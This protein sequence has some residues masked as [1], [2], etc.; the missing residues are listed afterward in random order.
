M[1]HI[2]PGLGLLAGVLVALVFGNPYPKQSRVLAR[3]LLAAT[4][5][6]LGAGMDL[7]AV[8][9][10]GATG[11]VATVVGISVC[12]ALGLLLAR[13]LRVDRVTGLLI[14]VGT[15]ICGGSAIAAVTPG[16]KAND[17]Q[18]T[19]S[20]AT[21]FLLNAVALFVFP[22]VGRAFGLTED[23][24]GAWAALAI[25]DTSSVVGAAMA[26][27]PH[28]TEVA[29]TMKLA[30]ALWIVPL[31]LGVGFF[32]ARTEPASEEKAP[33]PWFIAGFLLAAALATFVP[34]LR[35]PGRILAGAA[36]HVMTLTL[37]L[38]GAG[39]TRA[40]LRAV[41]VRPFAQGTVLWLLVS[42]LTLAAVLH[43]SAIG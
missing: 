39:L 30:R 3:H 28:A 5:V 34:A 1:P 37:F 23:Q 6:G 17:E 22:P 40:T 24:F 7:R 19:A 4:V 27:G 14:A 43:T 21:V 15:A 9:R 38:I 20:L 36:K 10:V 35:E 42:S 26:Y 41:G 18:V 11:F 32:A 29:T 13:V 2:S 16:L 31:T 33:R 12:L 25:H 8:A